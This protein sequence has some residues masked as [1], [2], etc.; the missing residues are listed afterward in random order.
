[1]NLKLPKKVFYQWSFFMKISVLVVT[2]LLSLAGI[3]L[4]STTNA[5]VNLEQPVSLHVSHSGMADILQKLE[6]AAKVKLLMVGNMDNDTQYNLNASGQPLGKVLSGFFAPKGYTYKVIN[7]T[8]VIARQQKPPAPGRIAG[9]VLDEK[10]QPLPGATIKVT[11]TGA[12]IQSAVD[13]S[14]SLS[15][16]AGNY[17]LEITFISYQ[18]KR[19]TGIAVAEGKVTFLEIAMQPATSAL[20]EVVITANFKKASVEGLYARQK[21]AAGVTDG[22]SAEQIARTPDKNIG[23]VLKRVTGLATMENKYVVVRGLSERYNQS[24]LDGLVMPSTELNRKN[25]SFDIIPANMV[26]NVTVSKTI[27]PDQSAEF[28]GGLVNVNTISVPNANFLNFSAGAAI[29]DKTTGKDFISQQLEGKEYF[30]QVSSHRNYAG[31]LKW[32]NPQDAV[33]AFQAANGPNVLANNWGLYH[34]KAQPSQNYQFSAGHVFALDSSRRIGAVASLSYR[35]TLAVQD[36]RMTR[37][38]GSEGGVE[39]DTSGRRFDAFTGKRYG[40]TTNIGALVGVGYKDK[41]NQLSYQT[42]YLRT[43]DQP[44][45]IGIYAQRELGYFDLT[46]QTSMLINQLKGE[47]ALNKKGLRLKWMGSYLTLD[48]ERPDNH[49][50]QA[51]GVQDSSGAG[52]Y[53]IAGAG[54]GHSQYGSLRT[55]NRAFEKDLSWDI[56]LSAPFKFKTITNTVKA[57][58]AGWRKDRMFYVLNVGTLFE[59]EDQNYL[60]LNEAFGP[61]H[62]VTFQPSRYGDD[63]RRTASLQAGYVML[64]DRLGKFRLVWGGRAEYYNLNKVNQTLDKLFEEINTGRGTGEK[65]DFTLLKNIEPNLRFF[66]SANLTYSITGTMNLRLG[67]AKSIIRPDLRELNY[68]QEYDFELGDLYRADFLRSTTINNYDFR[69]EWYPAAGDILS[70]SLFRKDLAYPM[71][72]NRSADKTAYVLANS[73]SARNTGIE[74]EFRKSLAFTGIPVIRNLTLYGNATIMDAYVTP[75]GM[76]YNG[77]DTLNPLKIIPREIIGKSQHRPQQGASNFMYNA[78]VYYD[79]D[80]FGL[81]LVYNSVSNRLFRPNA[82]YSQS[83]FERPLVALDGQ[84]AYRFLGRHAEV[85]LNVS[86]LLNSYQVVYYNRYDD[87]SIDRKENPSTKELGYQQGIDNIEYESKPGRTYSMTLSYKF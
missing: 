27:T 38:Y 12:A 40:F 67:F 14:Y 51:L 20:N 16:Q 3:S 31:Q 69:Y 18:T 45:L 15:L 41:A 19:I 81:S 50:L 36:V 35:N 2:T 46:T 64:D 79:S 6:E 25:F 28:G 44:L 5:Q 68:F 47:H 77:V 29:N 21:N 11:G 78:G 43:L 59:N 52:V 75:M 63:S 17:T 33:K 70:L 56:S 24:L 84:V 87:G 39:G 74:V 37:N 30:A 60:P 7:N 54:G 1:M 49:I 61:E 55:W 58:Y 73:K 42:V 65:Y 26:E 80:A 10:G 66:P 82:D 22:I 85:K 62:G 8:I 13:G 83:L 57:G 72:I 48:R 71:E 9:R 4:A 23:E 76:D 86:N 32:N 34:F 53:N